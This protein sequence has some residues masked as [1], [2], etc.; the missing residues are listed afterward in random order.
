MKASVITALLVQAFAVNA[1]QKYCNYGTALDGANTC[2]GKGANS[3][4]CRNT[5]SSAFPIFRG[6]CFS[7]QSRRDQEDVDQ[8]CPGGSVYCCD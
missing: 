6:A 7:P 5:Q 1:L 8:D 4:C 2:Q 3:Y